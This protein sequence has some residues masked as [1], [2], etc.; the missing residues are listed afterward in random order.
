VIFHDR[1]LQELC[2]TLPQSLTQFSDIG[3]VGERKLEKYGVIFLAVISEHVS[4][5]AIMH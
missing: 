3:G 4:A 2:V 5:S 1:T